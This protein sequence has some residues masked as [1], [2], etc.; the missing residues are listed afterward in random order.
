MYGGFW[1][2][3][4]QGMGLKKQ[5]PSLWLFVVV[6]PCMLVS[7]SHQERY[8]DGVQQHG[9]FFHLEHSS[10]SQRLGNHHPSSHNS[11]GVVQSLACTPPHFWNLA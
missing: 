2:G 7:L 8:G 10:I 6:P 11:R 4:V 5:P 1:K 9:Q 3:F